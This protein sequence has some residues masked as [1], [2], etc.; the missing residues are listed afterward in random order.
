M[1]AKNEIAIDIKAEVSNVYG[2]T[3]KVRNPNP[4]QP[5]TYNFY[6]LAKRLRRTLTLVEVTHKCT[7][8]AGDE[9]PRP[10]IT[11]FRAPIERPSRTQL[12][13][14][15]APP[16]HT[17]AADGAQDDHACT[18]EVQRERVDRVEFEAPVAYERNRKALIEDIRETEGEEAAARANQALDAIDDLA[19]PGGGGL[20]FEE[21]ICIATTG[22]HVE[23][24]V[25]PC[26]VCEDTELRKKELE[27]ERCKLELKKLE[28]EIELCKVQSKEKDKDDDKPKYDG[29]KSPKRSRS[30]K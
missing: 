4:C 29:D 24:R 23:A 20:I 25:S 27:V 11:T 1:S 19:D 5:V 6:Q 15:S 21:E 16:A 26:A 8:P 17:R 2:S 22:F 28:C 3:R 30:R 12:H 9:T 14:V 18:P 13:V 7:P 10:G